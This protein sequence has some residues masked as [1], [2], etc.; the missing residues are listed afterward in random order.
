MAGYNICIPSFP[1]LFCKILT[2]FV[3]DVPQFKQT[4]FFPLKFLTLFVNGKMQF[5]ML[6]YVV[7]LG[8]S[9][10]KIM[11]NVISINIFT[12]VLGKT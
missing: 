4:S 10:T 1:Q 7:K 12:Q 11:E 6:I 2:F 5:K 3:M 9:G 8:L